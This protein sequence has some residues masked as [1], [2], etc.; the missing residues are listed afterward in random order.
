MTCT[1]TEAGNLTNDAG[2]GRLLFW[3]AGATSTLSAETPG[4]FYSHG[5]P[6]RHAR[7]V[8]AK[9]P[10]PQHSQECQ[11]PGA[12]SFESIQRPHFVGTVA[13]GGSAAFP[14]QV[15][16]S[17]RGA[18]GDA[19]MRDSA[20]SRRS[21]T[22]PMRIKRHPFHKLRQPSPRHGHERRNMTQ[23]ICSVQASFSS[24]SSSSASSSSASCGA[25]SSCSSPIAASSLSW[26][27]QVHAYV[28]LCRVLPTH[29]THVTFSH[30]VLPLFWCVVSGL[31]GVC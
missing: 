16:T 12:S 24:S 7:S 14:E 28:E 11:Y 19:P 18:S 5:P 21:T 1:T 2:A 17:R 27:L 4:I 15:S 3:L 8:V 6:S 20:A 26:S 9:T 25:A 31:L 30:V 10:Y 22:P 13:R 23:P 29:L